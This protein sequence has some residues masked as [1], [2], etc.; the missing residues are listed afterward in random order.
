MPPT[1]SGGHVEDQFLFVKNEDDMRYL[2]CIVKSFENHT[3]TD[4]PLAKVQSY[5]LCYSDQAIYRGKQRNKF[6]GLQD[7]GAFGIG[8]S[9]FSIA[10]LKVKSFTN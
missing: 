6:L 4:V 8:F 2:W 3:N 9:P 10:Q 1:E 5:L 7:Y